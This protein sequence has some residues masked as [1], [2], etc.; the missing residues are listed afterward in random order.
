MI[1][2]IYDCYPSGVHP[3]ITPAIFCGFMLLDS[4]GIS[5]LCQAQI[6]N[7]IRTSVSCLFPLLCMSEDF[8]LVNV[9][10]SSALMLRSL[11][12]TS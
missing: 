12:V 6:L 10:A 3:G 9:N 11:I 1:L 4:L 2:F 7:R 8:L 5:A